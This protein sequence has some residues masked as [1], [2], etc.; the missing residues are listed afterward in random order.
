MSGLEG[1]HSKR[2]GW[3]LARSVSLDAE[4]KRNEVI[5]L[6]AGGVG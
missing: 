5:M 1:D 2:C 3:D 6:L 4:L